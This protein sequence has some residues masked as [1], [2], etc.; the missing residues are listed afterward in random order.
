[1]QRTTFRKSWSLLGQNLAWHCFRERWVAKQAPTPIVVALAIVLS[2]EGHRRVLRAIGTLRTFD[3][4]GQT[5]GDGHTTLQH[6]PTSRSGSV[7]LGNTL[8][9]RMSNFGFQ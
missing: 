9:H 4:A 7:V 3:L 6:F 2:Q 1:M 8:E 5:R